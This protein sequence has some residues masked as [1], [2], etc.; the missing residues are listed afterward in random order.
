M[1]TKGYKHQL[2]ICKVMAGKSEFAIFAEQGTGKTWAAL[3][4]FEVDFVGEV[5]DALVVLAPKGSYLNWRDELKTHW[6]GQE[7]EVAVWGAYRLK[8]DNEALG[9]LLNPPKGRVPRILLMNIEALSTKPTRKALRKQKG[10]AIVDT[11]KSTAADYLQEF[12]LVNRSTLVV[13]E[14]TKI[15]SHRAKRCKHLVLIR[16]LARRRRIMSG[17]PVPRSPLDLWGQFLV[18]GKGLLP[19]PSY[20]AFEARFAVKQTFRYGPRVFS[21]VVG[22]RDLE[23]LQELI[24]PFSVRV[25]KEDCLDL[26]PKV[27]QPRKVEL[28]VEQVR[29]YNDLAQRFQSEVDQ[30]QVAT[31]LDAMT[32]SIRLHQVVMGYVAIDQPDGTKKITEIESNRLAELVDQLEELHGPGI[33][34]A[35]Y[36]YDLARIGSKLREVYGN[37]SVAEYWGG[38]PLDLREAGRVAFTSGKARVFVSNPQVGGLGLTLNTAR[39]CIYF[40]NSHNYEDRAQSEDRCHR[41]G[42]TRSVT[43]IDFVSEDTVDERILWNLKTKALTG[44][45][46]LGD[47]KQDWLD[48]FRPIGQ[49]SGKKV[50]KGKAGSEQP[51]DKAPAFMARKIR[52][53]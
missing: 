9:R 50:L 36:R 4:D 52:T 8:A 48:W 5:V 13:D 39:W 27:Y 17:L 41:I 43:Y 49:P 29:I 35:T 2:M 31:A 21:N 42:Q 23:Y 25:L 14:S 6:G 22:F 30:G 15:K 11:S 33:I 45:Q 32:R 51:V 44:K 37:E 46:V 38:V 7:P 24:K 3:R 10:K 19:Y 12:M 34:W 1:K 28:T 16:G 26:P 53:A 20:L 47:R 40:S 18:L